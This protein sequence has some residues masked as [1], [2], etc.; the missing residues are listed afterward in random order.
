MRKSLSKIITTF[1][2][3]LLMLL[4]MIIPKAS[5]DTI[6]VPYS[7]VDS[8]AAANGDSQIQQGPEVTQETQN[9]E[10]GEDNIIKD[11]DIPLIEDPFS[12]DSSNRLQWWWIP[13]LI[14]VLICNS[15]FIFFLI[16]KN[17]EARRRSEEG[18]SRN[19]VNI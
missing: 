15:L 12:Q 1:F 17:K 8:I 4:S 7:D 13:V 3:V 6:A 19:T 16:H 18:E 2:V 14:T 11:P 10:T 9:N 5:Q